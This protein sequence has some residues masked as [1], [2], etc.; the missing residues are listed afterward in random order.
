MQK[1]D[2]SR[3]LQQVDGVNTKQKPNPPFERQGFGADDVIDFT[4][5]LRAE[6][7]ETLARWRTGPLFTPPSLVEEDGNRG[8][9]LMPGFGGGA[10]WGGASYNFV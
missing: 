8:T 9:V 1:F 4:P 7:L 3:V 5:E 6:A 2:F 10:N